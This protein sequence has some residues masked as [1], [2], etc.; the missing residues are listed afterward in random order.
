MLIPETGV[1]QTSER[2]FFTPSALAQELFY[3][4]TRCG[5]Y[6]CSR[7]YAFGNQ[8]EIAMQGDHNLNIM[9][10]AVQDGA[11]EL[12]INGNPTLAASGQVVLFDCREPYRYRGSDGLEFTW[13][14][15]NGLNARGFYRRIIQARGERH[16]FAPTSFAEILRQLDVLLSSCA[17]GQPLREA[18]CSQLLHRVLCLLLLED[19]DPVK[20]ADSPIT[21][22]IHYM[23]EHLYEQISVSMVAGAVNLS[24]SH[25]SR[26]FKRHTGYSPY[27]YIVLR[28][29]DRAKYLL[30][31]TQLTV[32]E[33][34]YQI[35]YNSE[36]N[37][38]HGFQKNVGISP[39]LFRKYPI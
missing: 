24:P 4:P 34:A 14:L 31:S 28:R 16:V 37:F 11:L 23:N 38:I 39:S 36:E 2:Y 30:T 6:F 1:H 5:H 33:I 13:L 22:A 27:E 17:S 26:R 20:S 19:S 32:K 21:Q 12:N 25:F 18:A 3:Y 35:G 10:F 9:L 7:D 29:L 15:F 8:S